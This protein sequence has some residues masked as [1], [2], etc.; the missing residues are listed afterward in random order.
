MSLPPAII[1][2]LL[3]GYLDEVLTADE[4]AQ[5]E[6]LLQNEPAVAEELAKLQELRLA[7]KSIAL[8]DDDGDDL[9]F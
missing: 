7:L 4:L 8:A 5:V 6:K 3:T 9:P 1:D 2:Q